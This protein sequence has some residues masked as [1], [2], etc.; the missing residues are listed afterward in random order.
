MQ[1]A[2]VVAVGAREG[3]CS[4]A[5]VPFLAASPLNAASSSQVV[6]VIDRPGCLPEC[7]PG[8]LPISIFPTSSERQGPWHSGSWRAA[9]CSRSR[10]ST[11]FLTRH[12]TFQAVFAPPSICGRFNSPILAGGFGQIECSRGFYRDDF[13]FGNLSYL[14]SGSTLRT[15]HRWNPRLRLW[16]DNPRNIRL[17]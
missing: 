7:L 9:T 11:P 10:A 4:G 17:R 16:N 12:C 6:L 13:I 8:P 14:A 1:G 3:H 2:G 5:N 15:R